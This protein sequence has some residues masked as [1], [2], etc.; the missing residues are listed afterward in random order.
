MADPEIFS[1]VTPWPHAG[2]LLR[3]DYLPQFGLTAHGL[4]KRMGLRDRTRVERIIREAQ[5]ITADTAL[6]LARVFGT[7]PQLW[8]NMQSSHDLSKMAIAMRQEL[9]A[10][11]LAPAPGDR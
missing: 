10:I 7:S 8:M 5:A 3:E 6:R 11:E 2:E 9:Q 4:A 1:M